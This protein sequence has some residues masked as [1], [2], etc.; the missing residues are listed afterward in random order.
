[1][2]TKRRGISVNPQGGSYL[3]HTAI[4]S[5]LGAVRV[6]QLALGCAVISLV[7]HTA[8]YSAPYGMF[9]MVVWSICF[10]LSV[11]I[12]ILDVTWLHSCLPVSWDNLTV[13]LAA[14][15][16]L[17][18]LMASILYPVYFVSSECPYNDCEV[19]NFRIA[20][21][22][23]S[24]A[25]FVAY[26]AEV[27]LSRAKPGQAAAYMAT[28]SGLLKVVQ[29]FLGCGIFATRSEFSLHA[30]T[31]YCAVVFAACLAATSLLVALNVCG[32]AAPLRLPSDRSVML[33]AFAAV[34]LYLSAAVVWPI[35]CFDRKY[36]T[37]IRPQ[38]CPRGK[39]A[40]DGQLVVTVLCFINL[41]LYIADL[42]YSQRIHLVTQRPRV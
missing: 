11:A 7:A 16:T 21:T 25:A 9:C 37:P 17:L 29:V 3:N 8:G 33:Y 23:F 18:Y 15:A 28:P 14:S 22:A 30:A 12:F 2:L 27:F 31:I 4:F 5:P 13:T 20:V 6:V 42:C 36:G 19:R 26:G 24:W 34:L 39:C 35:F 1:M 41:A 40:W 32:R 38:G 10:A